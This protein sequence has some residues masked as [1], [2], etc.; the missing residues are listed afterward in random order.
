MGLTIKAAQTAA[1]TLSKTSKMPGAST[2][3][4][5]VNCHVGAKLRLIKGS[6]CWDCYALKGAYR[7]YQVDVKPAQ[8]YRLAR[9]LDGELDPERWIAAMVRLIKAQAYFRWHDSGD[10]QG[11]WHLANILE[12][13]RRTPA[14]SHWLPTREYQMA[15]ALGEPIP[16]N[17]VIRASA[18]L[19]DGPAPQ[20]FRNTSTVLTD[21]TH[22]CP[23][24][25]QD[26]SCDAADGTQCRRC[27]DPSVVN[28]SYPKH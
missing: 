19:V 20:G 4:P 5:A 11:T 2:G 17:L 1:G 8:E 13:C 23:A 27:W 7:R 22:D 16:A 24:S 28:V 26:G 18:H 6:V 14:T 25:K 15:W 9:V 10:L 3:T 21:G 12:V